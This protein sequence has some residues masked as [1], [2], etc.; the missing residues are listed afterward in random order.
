MDVAY[1]YLSFFTDDD[2]E[3]KG[4]ARAYRKG[5]MLTGD[6]KK[7]CILK[8]REF[9]GAFQERRAV[10]DDTVLDEYMTVRPLDWGTKRT[11]PNDKT[12]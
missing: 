11:D 10:I 7:K 12:K 9:V 8:L 1:Q 6:L 2:D 4:I 3:L 5:E